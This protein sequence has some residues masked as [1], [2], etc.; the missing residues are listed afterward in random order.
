MTGLACGYRSAS[1]A[2]SLAAWGR[3][4]PLGNTGAFV[5]EREIAGSA[6]VD[7]M[8]PYPLLSCTHWD[9]L[10][11]ALVGLGTVAVTL[12]LVTDPFCSLSAGQLAAIF[13]LC[14][15]LH[16][17]YLIDLEAPPA[18]SRH[19]QRKLRKAGKVELRAGSGTGEGDAVGVAAVV[20]GAAAVGATGCAGSFAV[21]ASSRSSELFD[22][23]HPN[24]AW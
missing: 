6:A 5:I 1:Y 11:E 17:H 20:A 24:F 18:L 12:T 3:A 13:P 9:A 15:P 14:R 8:G 19:H 22:Q 10:G 16:D 2:A 21:S 7:L 23:R 4:V